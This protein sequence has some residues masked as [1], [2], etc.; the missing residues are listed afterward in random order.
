MTESIVQD[1]LVER[2]RN[3][4]EVV[5]S[6]AKS[7]PIVNMGQEAVDGFT[8]LGRTDKEAADC[9]DYHV[10]TL[11]GIASMDDAKRMRL[12][13]KDGLSGYVDTTD[14]SL[15]TALDR[16][17]AAERV[18]EAMQRGEWRATVFDPGVEFGEGRVLNVS[19]AFG[20]LESALLAAKDAIANGYAGSEQFAAGR[21]EC[22]PHAHYRM[23]GKDIDDLGHT[24]KAYDEAKK[25]E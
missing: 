19:G 10:K 18:V 24:L 7:E 6:I 3:N 11:R 17:T 20:N 21:K 1:D 13:A 23:T 8:A 16:A 4:A 5:Q 15:K 14:A 2:L 25:A 9:I 12:W 22:R